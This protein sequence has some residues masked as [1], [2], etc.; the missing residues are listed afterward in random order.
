M[1]DA[2]TYT[3]YSW[4]GEEEDDDPSEP[5]PTDVDDGWRV[6]A[7]NVGERE[8]R[9]VIKKLRRYSFD[10][11]NILIEANK[12]PQLASDVRRQKEMW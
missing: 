12:S 5:S 3:V 7:V 4:H 11:E 10:N 9:R 1:T 2:K 8:L 6:V